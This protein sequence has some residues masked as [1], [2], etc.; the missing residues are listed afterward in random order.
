MNH[1]FV[2]NRKTYEVVNFFE[3][4]IADAFEMYIL[5]VSLADQLKPLG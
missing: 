5:F 3:G 1:V 2:V 4:P